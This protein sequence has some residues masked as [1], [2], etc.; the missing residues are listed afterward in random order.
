MLRKIFGTASDI[1]LTIDRH[2]SFRVNIHNL[3]GAPSTRVK[4]Y[5]TILSNDVVDAQPLRLED[6]LTT[7]PTSGSWATGSEI[8]IT[9]NGGIYGHGGGGGSGS[10][11][12]TYDLTGTLF[13]N[14][15]GLG[16]GGVGGGGD[17]NHALITNIKTTLTNNGVVFGGGGGGGGGAAMSLI[18]YPIGVYS[19]FFG[20]M[21]SKDD[22]PGSFGAHSKAGGGGGGGGTGYNN[23]G[24][25][26]G[27]SAD[28]SATG[29]SYS[30]FEQGVA[31]NAGSQFGPGLSGPGGTSSAFL[32]GGSGGDGG[33]WGQP[34]NSGSEGI[35]GSASPYD[36]PTTGSGGAG[37]YS[38]KTIGAAIGNLTITTA[39]NSST[40]K[41]DIGS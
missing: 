19:G 29:G 25:G 1:Y 36:S 27:G 7:V 8:I 10:S 16:F 40:F 11:F 41:G 38:V 17:G 26:G 14:Y 39:I 37:G 35:V 5:L 31:G 30:S 28:S 22:Y 9:N 18:S 13:S 15:W 20:W 3:A 2:Q 12:G 6:G 32:F 33:D 24:G 21:Y 23:A 4:V 34:G